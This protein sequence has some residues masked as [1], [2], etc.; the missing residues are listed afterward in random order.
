MFLVSDKTYL[1]WQKRLKRGGV[2]SW[3][4]VGLGVYGVLFYGVAGL[5]LLSIPYGIKVL[6]LGMLAGF[7]ARY[8]VCEAVAFFHK[9]PH[10]YQ[11]LNFQVPV[12]WLLFSSM[13][14]RHDSMPSQH[15]ATAAAITLVLWKFFPPLGGAAFV[16]LTA[17]GGARIIIGYHD[18][19]DTLIG[20]LLGLFSGFIIIYWLGPMLFTR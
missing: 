16:V 2:F 15:A 19:M 9:K 3:A 20:W 10:P 11:R 18:V 6:L 14:E 5:Y 1:N 12:C 7:A 17:M 4:W 13:D 8:I